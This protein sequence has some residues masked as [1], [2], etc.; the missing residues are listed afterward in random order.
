MAPTPT[1]VVRD[2]WQTFVREGDGPPLFVSVDDAAGREPPVD[3]L[4]HGARVIFPIHDPGASGGAGGAEADALWALENALCGRLS[5]A[6]V[7]CLLVGRLTHDGARELVF[8][9]A[10]WAAFRPVVDR[11]RS[12]V[13]D[14]AV[15]VK[16]HE[17]WDFFD[18]VVRPS[19]LDRLFIADMDVIQALQNAGSDLEKEH[20]LEFVFRGGPEELQE[21]AITLLSQGYEPL[22]E[23]IYESGQIEFVY[24]MVPEI[25]AVTSRSRE[26]FELCR[27]VGAEYDGW[28]TAVVDAE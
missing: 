28:G 13:A 7:D 12:E 1:Q 10:D 15:E 17:G 11:W 16:E 24:H 27:E 26:L 20:A 25:T 21:L 18:E 3:H 14:Y 2:A 19:D 8:Q 5:H 22:D 6:G 9:L 23:L 4:V